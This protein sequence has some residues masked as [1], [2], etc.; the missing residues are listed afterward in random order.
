MDDVII[1][2]KNPSKYMHDIYMHFKVRDITDSHNYYMG[3]ELVWVV[4]HIH[5]S[6]NN[7]VN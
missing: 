1:A 4:N 3:N 5:V 2:A 7:H 6:S